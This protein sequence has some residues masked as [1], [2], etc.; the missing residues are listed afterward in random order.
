MIIPF[1]IIYRLNRN[2]L[3]NN[4]KYVLIFFNLKT[5]MIMQTIQ[6]YKLKYS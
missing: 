4:I 6:A 1:I 3:D 2:D 5:F